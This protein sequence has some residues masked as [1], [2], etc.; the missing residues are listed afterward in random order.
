MTNNISNVICIHSKFS[1]HCEKFLK[2][3]NKVSNI[4]YICIE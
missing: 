1:T 2:E 4:K 3:C